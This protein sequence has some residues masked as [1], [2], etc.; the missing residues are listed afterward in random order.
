MPKACVVYARVSTAE[1]AAVGHHSL[2]AQESLCRKYAEN[3]GL[4]VA[5]VIRDEGYSGRTTHRPGFR[6]L[7]EYAAHKPPARIDAVLVQDTSRMGRDTIEYVMFRRELKERCIALIAVT[8]PNIDASP[9][10]QLMDTIFAG[11]N[12]YQSDEKARRV[13]IA[14]QKKFEEGWWP[15]WAPLGYLNVVRDGRHEVAVDSDRA[16]LIRLAFKEYATGR[17]SQ[18]ALLALLTEKGL[19][20]RNG[21][22][23]VRTTFNQLVANP[24][25][26]G[27][28]RW[29][30]QER[31]GRHEPVTD[32]RTWAQCRAVVAAHNRHAARTRKHT[33]LL[34]GVSVCDACGFPHTHTVNARK[35]KRYY[36]CKS[37]AKCDAPYIPAEELEY[38]VAELVQRVQ[39]TDEFIGR[40]LAK[41]KTTLRTFASVHETQLR[42]VLRRK[43]ILEQRR[44]V[45]EEK[46]LAG[47]LN[48]EAFGRLMQNVRTELDEAQ[49]HAAELE[50]VR[51][52][53]TEAVREILRFARDIPRAYAEAPPDLQ[54]QYVRFF[55]KELRI[56]DRTIVKA[57]PTEFFDTLMEGRLVR[58][59]PNWLP[60]LCT[61]RTVLA[62]LCDSAWLSESLAIRH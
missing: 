23:V 42:V 27:R 17:Y 45:L 10:G 6:R 47:V 44:G 4:H 2:D 57:V 12:Q 38:H 29:N 35:A 11:I 49:R 34:T 8:Q 31:M 3:E 26:W 55:F 19:R 33:F 36:H 59:D 14:M 37:R 43:A 22:P 9:E 60:R 50:D 16:P 13:V 52:V 54:R 7:M 25:Y 58:T 30:G 32:R 18:D 48:D 62:F 53:D 51:R 24:F 15:G 56:R 5:E 40:V 1:Q 20:D 41:V 21:R 61:I 28:M 39:L 46:L